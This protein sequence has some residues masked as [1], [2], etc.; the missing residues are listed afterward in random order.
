MPFVHRDAAGHIDRLHRQAQS[1]ALEEIP[2]LHP[3]VLNFVGIPDRADEA[4]LRLDADFVRVIE[5]LID[6]LIVKNL[7]SITDLPA[8]VQSKLL[9]RKSFREKAAPHTLHLFGDPS[10]TRAADAG[11]FAVAPHPDH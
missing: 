9:A 11:D 6:V 4:F 1:D 5:D 7:I 10:G 2:A 8:E 3:E